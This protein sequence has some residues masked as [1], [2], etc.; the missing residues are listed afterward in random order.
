MGRCCLWFKGSRHD[1]S[2]PFIYL[3]LINISQLRKQIER[4]NDTYEVTVQEMGGDAR[5]PAQ[6]G[7]P[8]QLVGGGTV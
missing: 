8:P 4:L 7:Q 5:I 2:L 3:T 6:G 1:N